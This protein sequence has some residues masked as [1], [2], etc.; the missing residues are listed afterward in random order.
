M[1]QISRNNVVEV[2]EEPRSRADKEKAEAD[3]RRARAGGAGLAGRLLELPQVR[4]H[5]QRVATQVEQ[6]ERQ[7]DRVL[8][9]VQLSSEQV[10]ALTRHLTD[11]DSS[12]VLD[13]RLSDIL[14]S[15][16][17][18]QEQLD[19][20]ANTVSKLSRTQFKSNTLAESKEAQ[21]ET[22]LETLQD[23]ATH[24]EEW[25]TERREE[26]ERR[27]EEARTEARA[28]F[29]ADILPVLDG[30]EMALD[31]GYSLLGRWKGSL[32]EDGPTARERTV[33]QRLRWA[34]SGEPPPEEW[35]PATETDEMTEALASW[36]DGLELVHER[37]L[38]LLSAEGIIMIEAEGKAFDPHFHV[39]VG[40]EERTDVPA[41]TIVDVR[42]RG[43][44][45]GDRVL[46][47][48][49]VIVTRA[50]GSTT[51]MEVAEDRDGHE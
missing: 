41:D 34:L 47:Y 11:S 45:Q 24:R 32:Q 3:R 48:A 21:I 6:V 42:R 31:S 36:L 37:F 9:D 29:V 49:E 40:A 28:A 30:L 2:Q 16:E 43:Y 19:A 22:A 26:W 1:S 51:E 4:A 15:L 10:T 14:V 25:Q 7:L 50:P 13:E 8:D 44:R 17:T 18:N 23:I 39:A 35:P 33:L 20:L 38:A 46:R 27:L 5:L 12:R